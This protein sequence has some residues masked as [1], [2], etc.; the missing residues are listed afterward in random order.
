MSTP[1]PV[2]VGVPQGSILGPLLFLIYINDLPEC[3]KHCKSILYADDTLL[4]Y[5]ADNTS[6]L[7]SKLNSDLQ[8][9]STYLNHNLLTLNHDKTKFIIFAGRQHLKII[10]N[11]NITI[12]DRKINQDHALEY[13]GITISENL[14]WNGYIENLM[15]KIKQR[16]GILRRVKPLLPFN[17]RLAFYTATI[18]PLFDYA[19]I[20][21]G[22]KNNSGLMNGLQTL[23]N[24]AAKLILDLPPLSSA[25]E[26]LAT[27]HWLPL[28]SRRYKHRCI[29]IYKCTN[30]LF[31]FDFKLTSNNC[32]HSYNTRSCNNLHLPKANTNWGKLRPTYYASMD[33]NNLNSSVT[34]VSSLSQFKTQLNL[35]RT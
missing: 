23:E 3:L 1:K 9:L 19:D 6:E 17:A 12:Y 13:L 10:S 34:N 33:F 28:S 32:I 21:W 18:L 31:D 35:L 14:S 27:L 30:G 15:S 2:T 4:Y 22:D 5:S 7:Q 29:F 16:L 26:A 25:T 11:L 8:S 24:K 20:I